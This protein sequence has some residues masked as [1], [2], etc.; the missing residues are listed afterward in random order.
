VYQPWDHQQVCASQRRRPPSC[1]DLLSRARLPRRITNPLGIAHLAVG[2]RQDGSSSAVGGPGDSTRRMPDSARRPRM[3]K[4]KYGSDPI[5]PLRASPAKDLPRVAPHRA[6]IRQRTRPTCAKNPNGHY[7]LWAVEHGAS[8]PRYH[9][10]T[11][12]SWQGQIWLSEASSRKDRS[13]G[14]AVFPFCAELDRRGAIPADSGSKAAE[15]GA[16]HGFQNRR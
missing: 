9:R 12:G 14:G 10:S 3:W 13:A 7:G 16:R 4:I 15:Q 1:G 8:R 6:P 11:R 2:C 5:C